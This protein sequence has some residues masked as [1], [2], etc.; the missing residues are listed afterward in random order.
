VTRWIHGIS[1]D[2]LRAAFSDY[3]GVSEEHV[4]ILIVLYGRPGEWVPTKKL[5]V[6]LDSHRPPRRGAV[7]ERVRVLREIMESESL[8]S[9]GQL[10]D[11]GYTL[12]EVGF[13]ECAKALRAMAEVLTRTGPEV[14]VPGVYVEEI[15][16]PEPRPLAIEPPAPQE[17]AA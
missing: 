15:G 16:L 14:V 2:L 10:D 13:S 9:G 12:T 5:Q 3:F 4:D 6:L 17:D 1:R 8:I 11:I 7:H